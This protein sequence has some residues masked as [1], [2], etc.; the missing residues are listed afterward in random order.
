MGA[1]AIAWLAQAA[2]LM[3][4]SLRRRWTFLRVCSHV[5]VACAA[6]MLLVGLS[7]ADGWGR[8]LPPIVH[9]DGL[10]FLA[11]AV[12]IAT[13]AWWLARTRA[14]LANDERNMPE[15]WGAV[16]ALVMLRWLQSEADH[17]ARTVL[18]LPGLN[19]NL[20]RS[21]SRSE[22]MRLHALAPT[23]ASVGWLVQALVTLALGWWRRSAFLRWMGLVLVGITA[24]KILLVD[25]AGADP[26]WRFLAAIAA[27]IA[28]L[29][30]SYAYQRKRR[31]QSSVGTDPGAP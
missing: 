14:S 12:G 26:F 1:G 24:L 27:G 31:A 9:R 25:L 10:L 15:V 7:L 20:L 16:A 23:L 30:V 2:A 17:V 18:E 29:A 5:L 3:A 8:N 28:M 6:F 22:L 4:G 11:G 21:V 19:S 13:L